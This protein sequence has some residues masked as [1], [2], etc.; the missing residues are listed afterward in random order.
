MDQNTALSQKND[1]PFGRRIL[2]IDGGGILGTFPISFLA[3]IEQHLDHPI[4]DYFDLIAGTSTG[5]ILAIALALGVPAT[6]LLRL[7]EE[8]GPVIFG[9]TYSGIGCFPRKMIRWV[10]HLY[11]HKYDSDELRDALTEVLGNRRL[12]EARTR[13]IIPAWSPVAQSVYIYK[14]AHHDRIRTD[15][16]ALALDAALATSAAP[17]YFQQHITATGTALIDGGVWA[18]NPIALAVT[19]AIGLLKWRPD[20]LHV[21]SLGCLQEVY[22]VPK[23]VGIGTLG[24]KAINLFMDGQSH[25]AMGIA[26]ILTGD[27]HERHAIHR[28]DH[29]VPRGRFRMDDPG[30]IPVLKGLGHTKGRESFSLLQNIFFMH[31]AETFIPIY[32]LNRPY[33][34]TGSPS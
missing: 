20:E 21:L 13:L 19:E 1:S 10:R 23:W 25:G 12:G 11:R 34:A 31:P 3:E 32:S 2:S 30:L 29:K 18:S 17:T 9:Q 24:L 4:G 22:T 26:K 15:Y 8:K 6:D 14:T 16:K 33:N 5:G 7:Y 27:G 28:I